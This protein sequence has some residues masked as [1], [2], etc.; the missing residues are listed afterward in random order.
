M[1]EPSSPFFES[2]VYKAYALTANKK[3]LRLEGTRLTYR[4][5][6][7]D[8]EEEGKMRL[9]STSKVVGTQNLPRR[10]KGG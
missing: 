5:E 4:K 10:R 9:A 1:A 6:E 3:I 8:K 2:T 7:G